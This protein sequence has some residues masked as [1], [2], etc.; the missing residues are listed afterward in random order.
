[1]GSA[2]DIAGKGVANPAGAILSA[3]LLLRHHWARP[4]AADQ[5]EMAVFTALAAGARTP[6]LGGT[7]T[8]RSV[9]DAVLGELGD[10]G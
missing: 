7:A 8:T 4:E 2:P 9:T 5:L 3:A 1:H 6:D 10:G